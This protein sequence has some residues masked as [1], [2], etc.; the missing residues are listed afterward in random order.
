MARIVE[1]I[2]ADMN[3]LSESL[4][5]EHSVRL[6]SRG[7]H[8]SKREMIPVYF[9]LITGCPGDDSYNNFLYG[10]KNDIINSGKPFALLDEPVSVSSGDKMLLSSVDTSSPASIISGL[11]G[12]VSVNGNKELSLI[13]QNALG[14]MLTGVQSDVFAVGGE[15]V[16][17]L[18][19]ISSAIGV[20][21]TRYR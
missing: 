17:K 3:H 15:M 11:C 6:Y 9:L 20:N 8:F 12:L 18:R 5:E 4:T 2:S 1:T 21:D 16:L 10:L 19:F 13:A 7:G 14:E